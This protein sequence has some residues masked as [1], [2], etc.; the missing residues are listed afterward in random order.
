MKCNAG[1]SERLIRLVIGLALIGASILWS[2][3]WVILGAVILLTAIA[4]WCPISALLGI[5]TCRT[6][7]EIPADTTSPHEDREIPDRRFK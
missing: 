2:G 6:D 3:Y 7:E 4:G 5:S 1:K